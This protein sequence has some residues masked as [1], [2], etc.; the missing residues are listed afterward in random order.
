[1][2]KVLIA[3]IL[4]MMVLSG[5]LYILDKEERWLL[6]NGN[7]AEEYALALLK[8]DFSYKPHDKFIDYVVNAKDGYVLFTVEHNSGVTYGY[9][10]NRQQALDDRKRVWKELEGNW[11]ISKVE[12]I[13]N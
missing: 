13:Q 8:R 12:I 1:M 10:P 5:Y 9:F 3:F 6:L 11:F 2:K 7:D 4:F